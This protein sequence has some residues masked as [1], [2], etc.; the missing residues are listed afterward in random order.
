MIAARR[1]P[2]KPRN[3]GE[4]QAHRRQ[5]YEQLDSLLHDPSRYR[6]LIGRLLYL[7]VTSPG[8]SFVLQTLRQFISALRKSHMKVTT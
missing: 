8:I 7:T 5:H 3:S 4:K 2:P 1:E 6:R